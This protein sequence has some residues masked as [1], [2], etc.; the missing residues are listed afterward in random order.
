MSHILIAGL[1]DLGAGLARALLADGHRLS[2]IRR[3]P[4]A[5]EGVQLYRQDLLEGPLALPSEPVDLLAV[6]MTPSEYSE[7]GYRR[8][9]LQAPARLLAALAQRQPLPPVLFV[10]STAVFGEVQGEVGEDTPAQPGRY[11]GQVMLAAERQISASAPATAVRFSGIY[12]PGRL[13]LLRKV[14]RIADGIDPLPEA[15][16][17]NRIHRDDCVG[18]LHH[19]ATRWLAGDPPPAMVIGTDNR[20]VSNLDVQRWLARRQGWPFP[21]KEAEGGGEPTGKRIHS[22]YIDDGDYRLRYPDYRSGY[23]AL[24]DAGLPPGS[25]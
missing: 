8:A 15:V 23:G 17:S 9:Y 25:S 20:P 19:L 10:S 14:R 24:L 11:N 22:R 18:L 5:P 6:I 13:K 4:Q 12:G 1:G 2:G 16:W 3:G 7:S 21:G